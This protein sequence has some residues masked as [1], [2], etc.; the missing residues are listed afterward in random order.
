MIV[1]SGGAR[2]DTNTYANRAVEVDVDP[3]QAGAMQVQ[4][5]D[6]LRE[7]DPACLIDL[8]QVPGAEYVCRSVVEQRVD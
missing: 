6:L 7:N 1:H 3:N 5:A 8:A 2:L 4:R